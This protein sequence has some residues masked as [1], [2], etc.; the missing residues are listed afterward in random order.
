ML[1][2]GIREPDQQ[3]CLAEAIYFEA[4]GEPEEG[5]AAVAQ[6]IL[7]RVKSPAY[8]DTICEVVYQDKQLKY[9]CQFSFACDGVADRIRWPKD[10]ARAMQ[11]ARDVSSGKLW[12]DEIADCTNYHADYVRPAWADLMHKVQAV[13]SHIFYRPR[14]AG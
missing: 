9:Q 6:V 2:P 1:P 10:Y 4:S 14:T 3:E 8:P 5:Q 11:V 13:G 7:N 12:L